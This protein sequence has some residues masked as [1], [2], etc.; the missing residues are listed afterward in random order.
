MSTSQQSRPSPNKALKFEK[1]TYD[2]FYDEGTMTIDRDVKKKSRIVF[3]TNLQAKTLNSQYKNTGIEYIEVVEEV[4]DE[5]PK[6]QGRPRK[7]E[8]N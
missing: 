8:T 2:S 6:K 1:V 4:E 5:A 3:L 7:E